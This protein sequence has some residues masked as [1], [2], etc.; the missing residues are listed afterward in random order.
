MV[1]A[2][3]SV[4]AKPKIFQNLKLHSKYPVAGLKGWFLRP[5]LLFC[6][7]IPQAVSSKMILIII[8]I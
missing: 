5:A 1:L 2:L 3:R 7:K 4:L 8:F 6:L